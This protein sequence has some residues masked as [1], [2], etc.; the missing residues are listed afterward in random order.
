VIPVYNEER[1]VREGRAS[2]AGSPI[3]QGSARPAGALHAPTGRA[4]RDREYD[5][6]EYPKLLQPILENK[7]DVVYG[8]RSKV[9]RRG[10]LQGINVKL[11][12]TTQVAL[13]KRV[14]S[15]SQVS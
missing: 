11:Q 13:R 15:L 14:L 1:R 6:A 10:V 4:R 2:G 5:P 12:K 8:S 9:F 3:P 7:A